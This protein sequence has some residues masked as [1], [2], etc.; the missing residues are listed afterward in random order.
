ML[1]NEKMKSIGKNKKKE[2][3]KIL[4]EEICFNCNA[5][6]T[7]TGSF[8]IICLFNSMVHCRGWGGENRISRVYWTSSKRRR[9]K[10]CWWWKQVIGKFPNNIPERRFLIILKLDR[11]MW[12]KMS[13]HCHLPGVWSSEK[14][15][16]GDSKLEIRNSA[17]QFIYR[18]F[19]IDIRW[20]I[21]PYLPPSTIS[22]ISRHFPS[23]LTSEIDENPL[24]YS[25][26]ENRVPAETIQM[27]IVQDFR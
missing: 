21:F 4:R 12:L 13:P 22:I 24:R 26:Y 18:G 3:L 1:Q 27:K 23:S 2:K 17:Y 25:L 19:L 6:I 10:S 16:I 5:I 11:L 9:G 15:A 20:I 14:T 7:F 8:S